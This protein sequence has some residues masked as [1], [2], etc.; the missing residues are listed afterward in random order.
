M[1]GQ[2]SRE[3]AE[4]QANPGVMWVQ[5]G[6]DDLS[7][8]SAFHRIQLGPLYRL[9]L[10]PQ[11]TTYVP[12]LKTLKK[13]SQARIAQSKNYQKSLAEL[14]KQNFDSPQIDLFGQSD[15]QFIEALS[16]MKDLVFLMSQSSGP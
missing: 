15:L 6:D 2:R 7:D 10:Q 14:E 3:I 12:Y 4:R 11:L 8:I 5:R 13:N 1:A 9:N 16:V